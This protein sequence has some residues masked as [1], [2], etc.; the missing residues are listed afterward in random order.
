MK[1]VLFLVQWI[2]LGVVGIATTT[3]VV[4]MRVP[5]AVDGAQ[6]EPGPGTFMVT[7]LPKLAAPFVQTAL[8]RP[9]LITGLSG[10]PAGAARL[11]PNTAIDFSALD[12]TCHVQNTLLRI[13]GALLRQPDGS[14]VS[15]TV[16]MPVRVSLVVLALA[17]YAALAIWLWRRLAT[18]PTAHGLAAGLTISVFGGGVLVIAL[19]GLLQGDRDVDV[20]TPAFY[21]PVT[22]S[23]PA[24][25][26]QSKRWPGEDA[27]TYAVR[28]K[29]AI[30]NA[31]IETPPSTIR[32]EVSFAAHWPLRV[33]ADLDPAFMDYV[34]WDPYRTVHWGRGL[35][36]PVA[37]AFVGIARDNGLDARM[38]TLTGHVVATAEVRPGE[39]HL[40]D[41]DYGVHIPHDLKTVE[42][43]PELAGRIYEA[44]PFWQEL[45]PPVRERILKN[46]G[47]PE[48]NHI[49]PAGRLSYHWGFQLAGMT[50]AELEPF[51]DRVRFVVPSVILALGLA[52][53]AISLA[54][55]RW[56][57][58]RR[59]AGGASITPS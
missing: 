56:P 22:L 24:F 59:P 18:T 6:F 31:M 30:S 34:Y 8:G 21:G 10:Q 17:I 41:P 26:A 37:S 43:N 9:V 11:C 7:T 28:L 33:L 58:R 5:L 49:D 1:W 25:V 54:V 44:L 13:D 55:R 3:H 16:G 53:I 32:F 42:A 12:E 4:D 46:Y 47:T 27:L 36:G 39:W 20:G 14:P 2:A 15:I 45:S 48:D 51:L 57:Q 29:R 35:C 23:Y 19:I 52:I 40:F 50:H 38:V